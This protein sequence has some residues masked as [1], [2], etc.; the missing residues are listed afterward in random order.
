[1]KL[2][3]R[4]F[5]STI[6]GLPYVLIKTDTPYTPKDFPLNYPNKDMDIIVLAGAFEYMKHK[7][8]VFCSEYSSVFDLKIVKNKRYRLYEKGVFHYQFDI[9][10]GFFGLPPWFIRKSIQKSECDNGYF[11]APVEYEIV[12]R[13]VAYLNKHK[14]W[15]LDYIKEHKYDVDYELLEKLSFFGVFNELTK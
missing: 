9:A 13:L 5:F 15:H 11:K 1:M 14:E 4:K 12:Y 3:L 8:D 10:T 2:D 6:G 7:V